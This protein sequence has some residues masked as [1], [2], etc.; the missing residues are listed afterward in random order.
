MVDMAMVTMRVGTITKISKYFGLL[1]LACL[2]AGMGFVLPVNAQTG[3]SESV[4]LYRSEYA[5]TNPLVVADVYGSVHVFWLEYDEEETITPAVFH[6]ELCDGIWSAPGTVLTSSDGGAMVGLEVVS[7]QQGKIHAIWQGL[8]SNLYYSS[9]A[10]PEAADPRAWSAPRVVADAYSYSGIATDGQGKVYLAYSSSTENG[11]FLNISADGGENWAGPKLVSEPFNARGGINYTPVAAGV[12]GMVA[13]AWSEFQY[14]EAWPPLGVY[15]ATSVDGGVT[16]SQPYEIA[17]GGYD[18]A[19]VN[20]DQQSTVYLTWNGMAGVGGRYVSTSE[21]NGRTWSQPI[22]LTTAGLGASSGY[23][24][25]VFDS[26]DTAH[27]ITTLDWQG[28]IQYLTLTEAGWSTGEAIS[29]SINYTDYQ[30]GSIEFPRASMSAGN[31][32]H[33]VYEV[34]YVEIYYQSE[35]VNA[36]SL[37]TQVYVDEPPQVTQTVEPDLPAATATPALALLGQQVLPVR[38]SGSQPILIGVL[39]TLGFI[40]AVALIW[41]KWKLRK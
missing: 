2:V 38:E 37:P 25:I 19:H 6:T 36:P 3:W 14:P 32:L 30:I 40:V 11:V 39:F 9:V 4:L 41:N 10:S 8:N 1:I 26:Q 27:L 13:I 35:Q 31:L 29:R 16:W 18:Q 17:R 34:G 20:I 12:D 22:T 24:T 5:V 23:P 15:V 7:D 21:D 33:V 28:G